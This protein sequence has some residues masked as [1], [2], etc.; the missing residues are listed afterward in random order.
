MPQ[1][2]DG[3][4]RI[5]RHRSAGAASPDTATPDGRRS[6]VAEGWSIIG[7]KRMRTV[8]HIIGQLLGIAAVLSYLG[9]ADVRADFQDGLAAYRRGQFEA[10]FREW[11]PLARAG[12]M[13]A[14]HNLAYMYQY[15]QGVPH[16]ANK[17]IA[18]YRR[19]AEAGHVDAAFNL[20]QIF[21]QGQ[22][23]RR[24]F[25]L[26]AHWYRWAAERGDAEAQ[27]NLAAMH[28][29]GEGMPANPEEAYF[30][31]SLSSA[32]L[33]PGNRRVRA[34]ANRD[35]AGRLLSPESLDRVNRRLEQWRPIAEDE[36]R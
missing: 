29:A 4:F 9:S 15:G 21:W 13:L 6:P 36:A 28:A 34:A 27:N 23:I 14:Q 31:F 24:D 20:A 26:A 3:E 12:N 22:V 10:A 35:R 17:A 1:H 16:D 19:S 7:A 30:W 8:G 32:G 18:W 2:R 11:R 5:G 33:P 25:E